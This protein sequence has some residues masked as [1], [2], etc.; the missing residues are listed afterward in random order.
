MLVAENHRTDKNGSYYSVQC[1]GL[2]VGNEGMEK[3]TG[4]AQFGGLLYE[5]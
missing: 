2:T 3:R 1:K 4:T 5:L